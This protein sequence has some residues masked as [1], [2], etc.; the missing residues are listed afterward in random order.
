M[1]C[2][3]EKACQAHDAGQKRHSCLGIVYLSGAEQSCCLE[4]VGV[5]MPN[6][7]RSPQTLAVQ[8]IFPRNLAEIF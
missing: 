4:E 1:A 6:P 7:E 8:R 3:E 5:R 2:P